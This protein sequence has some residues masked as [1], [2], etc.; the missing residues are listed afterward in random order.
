MALHL[1]KGTDLRMFRVERDGACK[2]EDGAGFS[3]QKVVPISQELMVGSGEN[4][5]GFMAKELKLFLEESGD[6]PHQ[7][8]KLLPLS[9]IFGFPIE[10]T[11]FFSNF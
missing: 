4:L 9:F 2:P 8:E 3:T 1:G 5:F 7:N 6:L 10:Q 11:G